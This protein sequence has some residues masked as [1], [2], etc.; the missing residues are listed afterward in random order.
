MKKKP[1]KKKTREIG[2]FGNKSASKKSQGLT[3][4]ATTAPPV[5]VGETA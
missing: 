3:A 4:A 2:L 5:G 1:I